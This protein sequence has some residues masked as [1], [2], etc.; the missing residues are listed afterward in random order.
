[1]DGYKN[2]TYHKVYFCGDSNTDIKLI[3]C[4]DY[5]VILS[6]IQSYVLHWYHMYLLHPVMYR[7]DVMICQHLYWPNIRNSAQNEVA[8]CDTCQRTK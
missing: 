7:E 1:M 4:K 6:K 3:M 2:G 5:I 8:T